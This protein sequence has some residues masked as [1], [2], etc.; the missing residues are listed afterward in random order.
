MASARRVPSTPVGLSRP[1]QIDVFKQL[2]VVHI[3]DL[4]LRDEIS[5]PEAPVLPALDELVVP[6]P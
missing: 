6:T 2:P 5:S 4:D 3:E 1:R